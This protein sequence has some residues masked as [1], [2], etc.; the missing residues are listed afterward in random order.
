LWPAVIAESADA[1][2]LLDAEDRI[3]GW[4]GAA[5]R[6]FGYG[7]EEMLGRPLALLIPRD[8]LDEGEDR[9]LAAVLRE[10]GA[11]TD[12]ET[13]RRRRD[14]MEVEVSLTRT[15]IRTRSGEPLGS[16][17]VARDL[18]ER[19]RVER[20]II[21]SEKLASVGQ[22]AASVA[23]EIGAPITALGLLIEQM[24]RDPHLTDRY[25]EE[26]RTIEEVLERVGRL[27]RQL[28]DLAKPG[29]PQLREVDAK[30]LV[31]DTLA[32]MA[33]AFSRGGIAVEM[34]L[35]GPLPPVEADPRQ[36]E[37][38]L[39]NLLLNAQRAVAGRRRPRIVLAA[40][41]AEGLPAAGRPKR[42]ALEIRV[43]DNG[44]GIEAAD[45]PHIFTPF[46]SR[47]GGSGLGL[48]VARQLLHRH[49]GTLHVETPADG[50]ATFIVQ[51]PLSRT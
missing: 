8:L 36:I 16:V 18:S 25:A 30:A 17:T 32:L 31:R 47:F 21:E 9:A 40:G 1:I 43:S 15:L 22:V 35:D 11:I 46:F 14:G 51:L 44:P 33:P 37:Q 2:W 7:A 34:R 45:V 4:N 5:E 29:E 28:V 3:V 10:R 38:V 13:R 27:S 41:V 24:R 12:Y 20:Q 19:K 39:V 26:I 42:A 48:P 50:G 49:G 6:L 23:Q